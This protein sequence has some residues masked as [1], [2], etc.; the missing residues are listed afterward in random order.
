MKV[1]A[2]KD[3]MSGTFRYI[4]EGV[5]YNVAE[6]GEEDGD[7]IPGCYNI[8]ADDDDDGYGACYEIEYFKT[9]AEVRNERLKEL[10]DG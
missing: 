4:T 1:L 5:W 2:V 6:P 9:E 10:L 7:V 3:Y 8:V